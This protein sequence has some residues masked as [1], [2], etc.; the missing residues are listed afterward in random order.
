LGMAPRLVAGDGHEEEG[1][2]MLLDTG[3]EL[4][5]GR[6]VVFDVDGGF[7][8]ERFAG[9]VGALD[10]DGVVAVGELGGID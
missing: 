8:T 3:Y 9:G 7:L 4:L 10:L 1:P 5:Q 6:K 2:T